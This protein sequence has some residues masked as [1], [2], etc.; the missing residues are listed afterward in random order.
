MNKR[1]LFVLIVCCMFSSLLNSIKAQTNCTYYSKNNCDQ[2]QILELLDSCPCIYDIDTIKEF[3]IRLS[4][5][6][7]ELPNSLF[8]NSIV[9]KV[10]IEESGEINAILLSKSINSNADSLLVNSILESKFTQYK[11]TSYTNT[12]YCIALPYHIR[13]G[14]IFSSIYSPIDIVPSQMKRLKV[15]RKT[16]TQTQLP[17][18]TPPKPI[19]GF[20]AIKRNIEYPI[21]E[22]A[23]GIQGKVVIRVVVDDMGNI[24]SYQVLKSPSKKLAKAAYKAIKSVK[25]VPAKQNGKPISVWVTIPIY[26]KL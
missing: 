17:D 18:D 24:S 5:P 8:E 7:I 2:D 19:D 22:R 3:I 12:N 20:D 1:I 15:N 11:D 14:K 10:I 16:F 13:N 26:F 4:I 23:A 21:S 9:S 25:W 6:E